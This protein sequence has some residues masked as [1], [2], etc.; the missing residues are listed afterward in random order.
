M[1]ARLHKW[2]CSIMQRK[3]NITAKNSSRNVIFSFYYANRN[4]EFFV[5]H[6]IFT[7]FEFVAGVYIL[8]E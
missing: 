6:R 7:S 1:V 4:C 3:N 2:H 5:Y 8:L